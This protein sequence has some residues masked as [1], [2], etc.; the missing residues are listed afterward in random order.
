MFDF[1]KKK[2][3]NNDIK[4]SIHEFDAIWNMKDINSILR[5]E[6]S[7]NLIIALN[8]HLSEKCDYGE[9]LE[10]LTEPEKTIYL[11]QVLEGEINNGGFGQFFYN[12]SGDFANETLSALKEISAMRT[13]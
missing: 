4:K 8:G 5:I 13:F 9:L 1:L 6:D 2:S 12:S 10:K 11:C 3:K 7:N